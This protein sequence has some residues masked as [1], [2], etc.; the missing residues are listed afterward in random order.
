MVV[1]KPASRFAPYHV[2]SVYNNMPIDRVALDTKG[3]ADGFAAV[4]TD[5]AAWCFIPKASAKRL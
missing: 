3:K 1:I 5:R 2:L 4:D